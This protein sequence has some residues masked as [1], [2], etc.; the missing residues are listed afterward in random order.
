MFEPL[1]FIAYTDDLTA[2]SE[3]H[4]VHSQMYTDTQLY[5][6]S[7]LVDADARPPD[8]LCL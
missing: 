7:S 8:Q 3:K 6:S 1:G 4:N 2:V 5:D